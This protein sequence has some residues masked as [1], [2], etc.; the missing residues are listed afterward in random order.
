MSGQLS[1]I[2]YSITHTAE[3]YDLHNPLYQ[4]GRHLQGRIIDSTTSKQ[5]STVHKSLRTNMPPLH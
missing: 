2:H 4:I 5:P 3:L 1:T